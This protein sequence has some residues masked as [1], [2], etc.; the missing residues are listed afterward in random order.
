[1][2]VC[3]S[4][5]RSAATDSSSRRSSADGPHPEGRD[6]A[7]LRPTDGEDE[8]TNHF[9]QR[10]PDTLQL[11]GKHADG[12]CGVKP[13]AVKVKQSLISFN[14]HSWLLRHMEVECFFRFI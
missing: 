2:K 13:A 14:L 10:L 6:D 5:R 1:M 4:N 11:G 9:L 7:H 8:A 12:S 3:E